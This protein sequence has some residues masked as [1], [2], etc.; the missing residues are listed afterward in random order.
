[1]RPV[2]MAVVFDQPLEAG[3]GHQQALNAGQLASQ[4]PSDICNPVYFTTIMKNVSVLREYG[5]EAHYIP[6]SIWKRSILKMRTLYFWRPAV[7]FF[8]KWLGNNFLESIFAQH[9][10]SL[11]YFTS[12]TSL[13]CY[14]ERLNYIFTVWD[15]CHRDDLEFP[16]VRDDREFERRESL[17]NIVLRKSVCVLVDSKTS[18]DNVIRRYG[19]DYERIKIMPFSPAIGTQI[20]DDQYSAGYV[21]IKS[22]YSL[23]TSYIFYPAQFWAHKNH[24][25]ILHGLKILEEKYSV[26]ISVIFSGGDIGGNLEYVKTVVQDLGISDR[27]FFAGFVPNEEIIYLYSQSIALVMPTYF[28]PTNLPPL[29]AFHLGVP[30][31]YPD[32]S[33]LREQ[34]GNAGLLMDLTD[35]ESLASHLAGLTSDDNL[36]HDLVRRGKGRLALLD[37]DDRLESLTSIVRDFKVRRACWK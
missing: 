16:E 8:R 37:N 19:V 18:K 14:L 31:L 30:V 29:E 2:N 34:V 13:A 23:E 1:M 28:G 26:S 33:G 24:I 22:K 6:I 5:L 7:L 27:V 21:D 36:R 10:I 12:P 35:P 3:G 11:V 4:I 20:T 17:Y 32:K 15:L 9:K 25:Y